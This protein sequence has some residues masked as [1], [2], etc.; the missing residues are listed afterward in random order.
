M[1]LETVKASAC[2]NDVGDDGRES[3]RDRKRGGGG[4]DV[5]CGDEWILEYK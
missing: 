3:N 4:G 5:W 2:G 1:C